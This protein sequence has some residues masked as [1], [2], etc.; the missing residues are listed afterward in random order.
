MQH[1][2]PSKYTLRFAPLGVDILRGAVDLL[3]FFACMQLSSM[4]GLGNVFGGALFVAC[5]VWVLYGRL[6]SRGYTRLRIAHLKVALL[7][8]LAAGLCVGLFI[9]YP[10]LSVS[11]G[12]PVVIAFVL[13]LAV[14]GVGG[15]LCAALLTGSWRT[16]AVLACN[17]LFSLLACLILR[18]LWF[19]PSCLVVIAVVLLG[20]A[21]NCLVQLCG[22]PAKE[23]TQKQKPP[24]QEI[25][26]LRLY[27]NMIIC[28]WVTLYLGA[29]LFAVYMSLQPQL[30][31]LRDFAATF[32]CIAGIVL[33]TMLAY[34]GV[35]KL[36]MRDIEKSAVFVG[37]SVGWLVACF[38]FLCCDYEA[39]NV[40]FYLAAGLLSAS[41]ACMLAAA[42][43]MYGD[44]QRVIHLAT[45]GQNDGDYRRQ[46]RM[47]QDAALLLAQFLM[48]VLLAGTSFMLD[49]GGDAVANLTMQGILRW[50]MVA[51]P[52]I[53]LICALI[54]ALIQP[55][56]KRASRKLEEFERQQREGKVNPTLEQRL[57]GLLVA[58][59]YKRVG[60]KLLAL[61][62]KPFCSHVIKGKENVNDSDGAVIFVCNHGEFYG[63]IITNL[64]VP[65]YFRPWIISGMLDKAQVFQAVRDTSFLSSRWMPAKVAD[66]LAR[67][68]A[69][70]VLWAMRSVD[71]I[72]VYRDSGRDV[73]KTIAASVEALEAGDNILLF[74]E[75]PLAD[76]KQRYGADGS[77]STFYS[78]FAQVGCSYYKKTKKC[79]KFYPVYACKQRKTILF[80]EAV[81]FQSGGNSKAE[82]NRIARELNAGMLKLAAQPQA[83]GRVRRKKQK[84]V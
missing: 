45:G 59:H 53:F 55:L 2:H 24:K 25:T 19:S 9:A 80:G 37:G 60:L 73:L 34:M 76:G 43:R 14:R 66:G 72:P 62:V 70:L 17:V 71:P 22:V 81:Q 21:A 75:N 49:V 65:F 33:L 38:L 11:P 48:L 36:A 30:N 74:P 29:L 57:K 42:G 41:L 27:R 69:P 40:L 51:L 67:F 78:G 82:R 77:V 8:V 52:A 6:H 3:D 46:L 31:V 1:P 47:D 32:L 13:L 7:F 10:I 50:C 18:Q 63:P 15:V 26:A 20:G 79:V 84:K 61:M 4:L 83:V 39:N 16:L 28:L 58:K 44:L 12:S 35:R 23:R 56:D 5:Q 68:V 54:F 64:F